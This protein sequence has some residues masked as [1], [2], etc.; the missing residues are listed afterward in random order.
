MTIPS[1]GFTSNEL[2]WVAHVQ[3][4]VHAQVAHQC[5]Q[6]VRLDI[7]VILKYVEPVILSYMVFQEVLHRLE[8]VRHRM[9][10]T[11]GHHKHSVR[12]FAVVQAGKKDKPAVQVM[13]Q[14]PVDCHGQSV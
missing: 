8:H 6:S 10:M 4:E 2:P 3:L 1:L 12:H 14:G 13:I 7:S 5:L 9:F 11:V